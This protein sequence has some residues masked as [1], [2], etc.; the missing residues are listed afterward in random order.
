ML[1]VDEWSKELCFLH[2]ALDNAISAEGA[3]PPYVLGVGVGA[4]P[5]FHSMND[6]SYASSLALPTYNTIYNRER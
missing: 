2:L 1:P 5:T 6:A 3:L 4:L